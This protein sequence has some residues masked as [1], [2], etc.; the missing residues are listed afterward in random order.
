MII[1]RQPEEVARWHLAFHVKRLT[2]WGEYFIPGR[3][4]HVSAFAYLSLAKCWLLIEMTPR[5]NAKVVVWPDASENYIMPSPLVRWTEDCSI[6]AMDVRRRYGLSVKVSFFWRCTT[7]VKDLLG[8]KSRALSPEGLWDDLVRQ[9]AKVVFDGQ[10][11][12]LETTAAG[13]GPGG[14]DAGGADPAAAGGAELA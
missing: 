14:A 8:V 11:G 1:I 13:S 6:L 10:H 3:F 4:S 12:E 5:S 9:G 2:W 7:A